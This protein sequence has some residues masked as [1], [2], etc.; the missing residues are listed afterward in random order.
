MDF[1]NLYYL[2]ITSALAYLLV[3]VGWAYYATRNQLWALIFMVVMSLFIILLCLIFQR[4]TGRTTGQNILYVSVFIQR[5]MFGVG[6]V[7]S[8]WLVYHLIMLNNGQ[9]REIKAAFIW[10]K[11]L[12]RKLIDLLSHYEHAT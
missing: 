9:L 8:F 12:W 7:F 11:W 2:I 3:T 1:V 6:V 4:T 5:T 10:P